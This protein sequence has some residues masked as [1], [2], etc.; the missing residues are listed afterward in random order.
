M[1]DMAPEPETPLN[2]WIEYHR[3]LEPERLSEPDMA[4]RKADW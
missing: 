4:G 1:T 3:E 2:D